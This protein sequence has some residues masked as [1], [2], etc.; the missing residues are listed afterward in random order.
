MLDIE[1]R[2]VSPFSISLFQYNNNNGKCQLTLYDCKL[3]LLSTTNYDYLLACLSKTASQ[4]RLS[5]KKEMR[6][7]FLG[8]KL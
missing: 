1:F 8:K 4:K 2:S 5:I 7:D 6:E 3:Q